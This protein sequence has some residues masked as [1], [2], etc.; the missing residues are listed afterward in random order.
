MVILLGDIDLSVGS[1]VGLSALALAMVLAATGSVFLAIAAA[2]LTG[3]FVGMINGA[4]VA[5]LGLDSTIVTIAGLTWGRGL[6]QAITRGQPIRAENEF[7]TFLVDGE[8]ECFPY[9]LVRQGVLAF[10]VG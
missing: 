9:A 1:L 4:L 8:I 2:L 6:V 10:H 3:L 7:L 5:K